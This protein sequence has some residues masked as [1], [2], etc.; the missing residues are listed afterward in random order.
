MSPQHTDSRAV[1]EFASMQ[2]AETASEQPRSAAHRRRSAWFHI[3]GLVTGVLAAGGLAIVLLS[4]PDPR[5]GPAVAAEPP[6]P[7][8]KPPSISVVNASV[9]PITESVVVTGNLVAREEIL[10]AAQ[11]DGYAVE[12]ILAE[13]GDRVERGQVL[14]RLTRS[15]I[16]T[17][18]AQNEAQIAR[19]DAAIAQARSSVAEAEASKAQASSAFARTQTLRRDGISTTDTLEQREAAAKTAIARLDSAEHALTVAEA[20]RKLAEA[21][22]RELMVRFERTEIKAPAAGVVSRRTARI[23]AIASSSSSG[24]PLFRIIRDGSIE[25]EANVSESTLARL[26]TA[27]PARVTTAGRSEPFAAKVRLVSPEVDPNSRLGR[28]RIA[29]DPAPGLKL[30]AFGRASVQ[31]ASRDGVLVPQSA[32][33]YS[34]KG[35]T[36][37]L[38]RDGVVSTTPVEIG[39]R[40]EQR[41]EI[42]KGVAA[43]NAVVATAGTFVRDGDKVVSV[44]VAAN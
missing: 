18:L 13:E 3:S 31:I 17:A 15:M 5:P 42:V 24:E 30:G 1:D 8:A 40:T 38:V 44:P 39:L 32:V 21:Q 4:G 27:M 22:R 34:E 25:L 41:A 11:I 16:E 26:E 19:A 2:P 29:I 9:G 28:V 36:V 14:A 12:E 35:P 7:V 37:Q 10:V 6:T 23:G 20:D 43:G 33:L